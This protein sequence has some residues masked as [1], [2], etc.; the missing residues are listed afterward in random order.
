MLVDEY[1]LFYLTWFAG[2]P[3]IDLQGRGNALF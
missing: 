3:S 2:I 1:S